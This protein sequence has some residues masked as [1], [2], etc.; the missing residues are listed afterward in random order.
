[1]DMLLPQVGVYKI[2]GRVYNAV[3]HHAANE[4]FL[5]LAPKTSRF[6]WSMD[7]YTN[8]QK[9]GSFE[10]ENVLSGTYTLSAH[11]FDEGKSYA[12][13]LTVEVG[14]ADIEGLTLTIAPG[15][16]IE[17][18]L[19]WEGNPSMEEQELKLTATGSSGDYW[20]GQTRV[21]A[22]GAFSIKDIS[23]GTYKLSVDGISSDCYVKSIRYG[24]NDAMREGFT[25]Q[26]GADAALEITVSSPGASLK[27]RVVDVEGL[28]VWVVLVPEEAHRTEFRLY[29]S[30]ATDQHG[31]FEL[32]GIAPGDYKLFS[33]EEVESQA[34]EDPEFLKPFEQKGEKITF[35][36]GDQKTLNV[37]AIR[38]KSLEPK[39]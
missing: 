6:V 28:P 17:G 15:V 1:M 3:T 14:S 8:V 7:N 27:G 29:K 32:R 5:G 34:W 33:W 10:M 19:G 24:M 21:L 2:R 35:Q 25:V 26:R 9:D 16:T 39:P 38:A 30:K 22:N 23:E 18:Y 11:W 31:N 37:T 12:T 20:G 4:V 36:E 13:R